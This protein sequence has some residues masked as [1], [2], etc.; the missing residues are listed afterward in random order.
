MEIHGKKTMDNHGSIMQKS[1]KIK[2]Q[3]WNNTETIIED[4]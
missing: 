3:S 1:W 4:H 2:E